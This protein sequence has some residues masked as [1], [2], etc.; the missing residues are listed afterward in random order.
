M[1]F[2]LGRMIP[3]VCRR[4]QK[5]V[6][7]VFSPGET[8][9]RSFRCLLCARMQ[10]RDKESSDKHSLSEKALVRETSPKHSKTIK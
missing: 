7:M 1:W 9:L 2:L 5:Q 6:T 8:P 10:G 3:S 4:K